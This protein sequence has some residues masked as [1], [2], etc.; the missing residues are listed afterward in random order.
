LLTTRE[1]QLKSPTHTT[2]D[3]FGPIRHITLLRPPVISSLFSYSAPVSPP[4]AI[5]Y[6]ASSLIKAG[7]KVTAIDALGEAIE[8]VIIYDDPKCRVRGLTINEMIERIPPQTQLIGLSCMFSQDWLFVRKIAERIKAVFPHIPIIL[9]GEHATTMPDT[10]LETSPAI[11]MCILGEGEETITDIVKN[12]PDNLKKVNGIVYRRANGEICQTSPRVRIRKIEDIPRPAWHLLPIESYLAGG[13]SNHVNAGRSMPILATRG[14]PFKCTFCSSPNMWGQLYYTRPP[15]DVVDEIEYYIKTYQIDN[16][17]FYDLTAIIKKS[18]V[19]E[20]GNILKD[21]KIN[22]TWALPSGTRSEALDADVTKLLKDTGCQYIAY[23]AESG[24]PRILKYIKKEV[25][26]DRMLASM[27]AA[28]K[29][30]LLLRCNLILGF[31]KERR[32]DVYRTIWFMMKLVYYGIDDAPLFM[33]SPYP[34]TVMYDYLRQKGKIG[35]ANDDYF[36]TLMCFMD[37]TNSSTYCENI[38]PKELAFYRLVGMCTFYALSYLFYPRR[39]FRSI[40]SILFTKKTSTLFEQRI[41][42]IIN[43]R[44]QIKNTREDDRNSLLK[45]GLG[46]FREKLHQLKNNF[47]PS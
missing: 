1:E 12:Y 29:N 21:R 6:L 37:L 35:E 45:Y 32:S 23:A 19:M 38:G 18:W 36:R 34:G 30:G 17:D 10:I 7:F 2:R 39:I 28:K 5:A 44:K 4:L 31:P 27:K 11:E 20:F 40:R 25:K 24:S 22:I 43:T 47:P 14:C 8:K 15:S 33:F 9:G 26:L 3:K 46:P 13:H 42:E 16:I 41:V